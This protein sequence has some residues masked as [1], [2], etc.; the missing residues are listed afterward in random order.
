MVIS[1]LHL[2]EDV[3]LTGRDKVMTHGWRYLIILII[4]VLYIYL[5]FFLRKNY[6]NLAEAT[7]DSTFRRP[8]IS[9]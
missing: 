6:K 5:Y 9:S 1:R 4:V 8:R 3:W 2:S 7:G